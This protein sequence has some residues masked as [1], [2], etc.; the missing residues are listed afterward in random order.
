MDDRSTCTIDFMCVR[1]V[2]L[3]IY[4]HGISVFVTMY[5][6]SEGNVHSPAWSLWLWKDIREDVVVLVWL[7]KI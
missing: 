3:R 6:F 4:L 5:H 2:D 7:D 1:R